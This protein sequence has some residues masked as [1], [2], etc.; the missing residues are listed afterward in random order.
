MIFRL[1]YISR[2]TIRD[3][4]DANNIASQIAYHASINNTKHDITGAM[5][6]DGNDFAQILE[7]EKSE[8]MKLLEKIKSDERHED[9]KVIKQQ[10]RVA[11]HYT[12]WNMKHLDSSNYDELIQ[13]MS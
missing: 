7:G 5:T 8:V 12:Q 9:I 3:K 10:E 2:C 1:F 6:F 11:R 13:V 4:F